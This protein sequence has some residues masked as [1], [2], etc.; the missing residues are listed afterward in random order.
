[1]NIGCQARQQAP[2][3]DEPFLLAPV[4]SFNKSSRF[5]G[6][7]AQARNLAKLHKQVTLVCG[8][9]VIAF[10]HFNC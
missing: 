5:G 4:E 6:G 3:L 1:M 9:I 2:F 10:I 8:K 7:K